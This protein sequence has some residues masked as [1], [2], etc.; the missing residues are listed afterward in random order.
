MKKYI[1]KTQ[2]T[3][4]DVPYPVWLPGP[5]DFFNI[6][7]TANVPRAQR[8]VYQPNTLDTL[9]AAWTHYLAVA[10]PVYLLILL[11]RDFVFRNQVVETQVLIDRAAGVGP[12]LKPH[13]F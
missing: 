3:Q 10:V 11:V 5:A 4:L 2:R 1:A 13:Q 8:I 9:T 6:T 12:A 7:L